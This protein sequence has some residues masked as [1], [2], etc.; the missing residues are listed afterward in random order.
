MSYNFAGM[1]R[2][3]TYANEINQQNTASIQV[4]YRDEPI[5]EEINVKFLGLEIDK[6]MNW[7]TPIEY[8]LPKLECVCYVIRCFKHYSTIETF[9]MV[10]HA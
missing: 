5:Q 9:K 10:Y 7:K 2:P 4:T 6:D 1:L 3:K 8:M